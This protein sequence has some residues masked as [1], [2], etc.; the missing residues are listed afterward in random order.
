MSTVRSSEFAPLPICSSEAFTTLA[1]QREVVLLEGLQALALNCA[2]RDVPAPNGNT[3]PQYYVSWKR[4]EGGLYRV[5]YNPMAGVTKLSRQAQ[6]G[7]DRR[8][9]HLETEELVFREGDA[10]THELDGVVS[11]P[12]A[13]RATRRLFDSAVAYAELPGRP[14]AQNG[15]PDLAQMHVAAESRQHTDWRADALLAEF[16]ATM[17]SFR[18]RCMRHAV[19]HAGA[20]IGRSFYVS[21][22]TIH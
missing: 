13:W 8:Q 14:A 10:T 3:D 20:A 2:A 16:T 7:H 18:L 9:Q 19:R 12:I 5:L 6:Y 22:K 11:I 4:P 21:P 17:P 15:R 1:D